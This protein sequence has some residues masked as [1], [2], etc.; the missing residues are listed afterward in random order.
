ME[1]YDGDSLSA[2]APNGTALGARRLEM[3]SRE[4][5]P[6]MEPWGSCAR[7]QLWPGSKTAQSLQAGHY[8]AC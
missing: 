6:G 7:C 1:Q 3:L 2:G 5:G 8:C 4:G